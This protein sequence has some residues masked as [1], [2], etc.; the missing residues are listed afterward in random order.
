MRIGVSGGAGR[1]LTAAIGAG[2]LAPI[3]VGASAASAAAATVTVD[4][5][6]Y[7]VAQPLPAMT[8]TGT[9]FVPGDD[10]EITD[11]LGGLSASGTA[12]VNGD[13][14]IATTAPDAYFKAPGVKTDTVTATDAT[15]AG[16]T[17]AA[18]TAPLQAATGKTRRA[19]GLKAFTFTTKWSFSGFPE[20]A[21][22][23]GHYRYRRKI[24]AT[25]AFGKAVGPCGTLI[26]SKRIFPATPRHR[27]YDLQVDASRK[28]SRK[29]SP[30]LDSTLSL[31]LF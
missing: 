29:A 18:T 6:C 15:Q 31:S 7:V 5:A 3:A 20:G 30:K 23:Y 8:I 17:I 19:P 16:T 1:L 22:I 9:G 4:K 12:D 11:S 2:V 25:Q 10:V 21:T 27:S 24:V 13:I 26:V 14:D 28:Y